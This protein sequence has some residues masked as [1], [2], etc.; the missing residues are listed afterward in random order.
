MNSEKN[1]VNLQSEMS[2]A[3]VIEKPPYPVRRMG[4]REI[5]VIGMLGAITMLLGLTGL[6]FIPLVFMNATILQI[7]TIIGALIEGPRVGAFVGLI[8]GSFSLYQSIMSPTIMAFAF[9]N[10][11]VSILPRVLI[12]PMAYL[13]YK[14]LPIKGSYLRI[15]TAAFIGSMVNTVGVLGMIY[16]LYAKEFAMARDIPV[17]HVVNLLLGVAAVNGIPEAILSAFIVTPIV[18]MVRRAK[19]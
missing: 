13:V 5:V 12:G 17:D 16:I 11:L 15:G 3:A 6:G 7:P 1:K 2:E 4:T 14:I 8:F 9:L 10:P 19:R 18:Y